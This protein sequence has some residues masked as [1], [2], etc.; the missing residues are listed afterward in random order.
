MFKCVK[1]TET[2]LVTAGRLL[3]RAELTLSLQ[4]IVQRKARGS[5]PVKINLV[6]SLTNLLAGRFASRTLSCGLLRDWFL[7][8]RRC[9]LGHR[10]P[11]GLRGLRKIS[12]FDQLLLAVRECLRQC[13]VVAFPPDSLIPGS[14]I[15]RGHCRWLRRYTSVL[16][17][18][19]RSASSWDP[20]WLA[21]WPPDSASTDDVLSHKPPLHPNPS[22]DTSEG[23]R[24][25]RW[26]SDPFPQCSGDTPNDSPPAIYLGYERTRR[27]SRV[28]QR[29]RSPSP[30]AA[31]AQS[32]RFGNVLRAVPRRD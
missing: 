28:D 5:T 2:N 20:R 1:R 32:R 13:R 9:F 27:V 3:S 6:R 25:P 14:R 16:R 21:E 11:R 7:H 23:K 15:K 31:R 10:P 17:S 18:A 19:D 22:R 24:S 26:A 29:D 8:L 12:C 4:P 30:E